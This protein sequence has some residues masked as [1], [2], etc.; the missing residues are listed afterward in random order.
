MAEFEK[1]TYLKKT[2]RKWTV[3][4]ITKAYPIYQ[5][6]DGS[7]ELLLFTEDGLILRIYSEYLKDMQ[8]KGFKRKYRY[9]K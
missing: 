7:Y 6:K 9:A 3:H 1:M 2:G 5:F 8:I 4:R